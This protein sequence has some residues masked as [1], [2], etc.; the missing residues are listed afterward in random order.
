MGTVHYSA[1]WLT[2]TVHYVVD[3]LTGTVHYVVDWLT[4]TVHLMDIVD[5]VI[6]FVRIRFRSKFPIVVC[7]RDVDDEAHAYTARWPTFPIVAV[8]CVVN[9]SKVESLTSSSALKL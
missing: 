1:D 8:M 5:Q 9:A 3:W 7:V 2:G 6:D 4:G